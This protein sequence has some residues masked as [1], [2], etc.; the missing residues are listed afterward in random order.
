MRRRAEEASW[1][2]VQ[3]DPAGDRGQPGAGG[4]DGV[5]LLPGHGV[6]AGVRLLYGILSL[7]QRAQ[8]PVREINQLTPLAHDRAHDRAQARIEPAVSWLGLVVMVL[9]TPLVASALTSSTRHRTE[10]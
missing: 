9:P 3:A 10:M 2:Q 1:R 7:G 8:E 6:P 5:L 4:F